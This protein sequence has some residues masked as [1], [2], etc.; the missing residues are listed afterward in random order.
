MFENFEFGI[1]GNYYHLYITSKGYFMLQKGY[2]GHCMLSP[3]RIS[4]KEYL[5][6]YNDYMNM[7]I[8]N[9]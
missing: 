1:A 5:E 2:F 7:C 8:D 6:Y 9:D 4:K 3:R